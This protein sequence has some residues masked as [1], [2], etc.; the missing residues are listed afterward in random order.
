MTPLQVKSHQFQYDLSKR[1][2]LV[3]TV[4]SKMHQSSTPERHPSEIHETEQSL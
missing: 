3:Q 2:L 1:L 4:G